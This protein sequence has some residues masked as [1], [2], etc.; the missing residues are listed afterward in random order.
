MYAIIRTG[1]KQYKVQQGDTI[2]IEKLELSEGDSVKFEEILAVG[3]EG[4]LNFGAPF[5]AGASVE[6]NILKNGKSKKN[7]HL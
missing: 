7:N 2:F 5:V 4:S 1:G 3:D 6:A